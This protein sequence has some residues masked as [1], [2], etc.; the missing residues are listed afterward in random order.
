MSETTPHVLIVDD[1]PGIRMA[2]NANFLRQG[3]T[4]ETA[5]GVR[6]AL[7]LI[8]RKSYDLVISDMR[9]PD[10]DGMEVLETVRATAPNTAVILLTAHGSVSQA[11][12]SMRHGAF[13]YLTKPVSFDQLR[14]MADRV[15]KSVKQQE[16]P[17]AEPTVAASVP[18]ATRNIVGTSPALLAA[19][20]R[21]RAAASTGADVL[22]EAESGAGKE[23]LARYIHDMSDRANKPF[24]AVNC[25]AVPDHLIESELFGHTKGAFTGATG[26]RTG[27]F[28]L[29]N[30][31]TLLLDEIGE[32]PLHLQ[33]KLL[34]VLQEREFERLGDTRTLHV[35]IRIIATTNAGLAAMVERGSFRHDLYYRLNVIPLSLPPLRER[36]QDLPA[37]AQ[38]FALRFGAE[39]RCA[40][41]QLA[42]SFLAAIAR[43][44]WPGNVREFG[45]F[46]RRVLSLHQGVVIDEACFDR[47]FRPVLK[48]ESTNPQGQMPVAGTRIADLERMHLERTLVLTGGNRT[49]AAEM[50]G[51]SLRTVRNKIKEY[52]LPPRSYA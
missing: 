21:A 34:R 25:A 24:V 14:S 38:H 47:E 3:W 51:V 33:P 43:H 46:M 7:R 28:E 48:Q 45:N 6:E 40:T 9:M 26:M 5:S 52:G 49:H 1:D 37:L 50:L 32:M 11:V 17:V 19:L 23:L 27:K 30:G 10:G 29:A 42:P 44:S 36:M 2:L 8:D 35:D 39:N 20:E 31:G 13:D 4:S 22:V 16:T 15:L 18:Q 41:P 12:E